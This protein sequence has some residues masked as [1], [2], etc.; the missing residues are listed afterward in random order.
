MAASIDLRNV[1]MVGGG[2]TAQPDSIPPPVEIATATRTGETGKHAV[3][4]CGGQYA[5]SINGQ[6]L[7]ATTIAWARVAWVRWN[8]SSKGSEDCHFG[9]HSPVACVKCVIHN[10]TSPRCRSEG[11]LSYRK[12]NRRRNGHGSE[13]RA[14]SVSERAGT[15]GTIKER[16]PGCAD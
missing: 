5:S 3:L 2:F 12:E 14:D 9:N 11:T 4:V 6:E 8:S 7:T 13:S 15:Q 16:S 10:A 1:G